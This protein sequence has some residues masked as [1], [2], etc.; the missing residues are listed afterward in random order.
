MRSE[1][2]TEAQRTASRRALFALVIFSIVLLCA[3]A[4]PIANALFLAAVLGGALYPSVGAL[5]RKLRLKRR[6]IA[7]GVTVFAV[8]LVLVAPAS[9]LAAFA[10]AEATE[11]VRFVSDAVRS[12]GVTGLI[13]RLP[14]SAARV[15]RWTIDKLPVDTGTLGQTIGSQA[16]KAALVVGGALSVTGAFLFQSAMMLVALYAL[17]VEGRRLVVWLEKVS[18][19]EQGQFTE[20]LVEFRRTTVAVMVSSA[21]TAG[22]QALAALVGYLIT[23]VPHPVFF[24]A[25][26]FFIAFVP[27]VGAASVCIAAALLLFAT[28][29]AIAAAFLAVW[30]MTV[31]A[32]I[33]NIVKPIFAKRG[34]DMDGAVIFF[35]LIGGVASFG[36]AGLLIGPL[37]V[38]LFLTVVRFWR[39][40]FGVAGA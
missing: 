28:G 17:L 10:I 16:G 18:P 38:V 37:A 20:L 4:A 35:A 7:A 27:A 34:M 8:V 11:A 15:V 33:D 39:R 24:T 5:T 13:D 21:A 14:A 30:A 1:A 29:H 3:V 40:S 19:L 9:G 12:E 2:K 25:L 26:T 22:V 6:S 32:L 31:V 36:A 23:R